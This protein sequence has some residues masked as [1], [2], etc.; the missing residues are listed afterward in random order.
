MVLREYIRK[1]L[2]GETV[3]NDEEENTLFSSIPMIKSTLRATFFVAGAEKVVN[4]KLII[5][6][7]VA[8]SL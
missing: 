8:G 4:N 7:R 3:L 6:M 5:I 2:K 1:A